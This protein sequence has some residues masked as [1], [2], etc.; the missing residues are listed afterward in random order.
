MTLSTTFKMGVRGIDWRVFESDLSL[1]RTFARYRLD[2]THL[3]PFV[4]P[5]DLSRNF[6]V[7]ARA[8]QLPP[9]VFV[10]PNFS[11]VPP[12]STADDDLSPVH[13]AKGQRFVARVFDALR[14]STQWAHTLMIVVYDEHGGFFDHVAPPGTPLG[15]PELVGKIARIHPDGADH[16]GV[17]VPAIFASPW[18]APGGVCHQVFDHTSI[19]KTILLRHRARF[20]TTDFTLLGP[21]VN[22]AAHLGVALSPL[23]THDDHT[24][25]LSAAVPA[26]P[27]P[28]L[29]TSVVADHG[30][31]DAPGATPFGE[32]LYRSF[33]PH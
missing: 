22:Q 24:Q 28:R 33:L 11:D 19:I 32:A 15:P 23:A 3:V 18:V 4:D 6:E 26:G 21:R 25:P 27:A 10:E 16:L 5:D 14:A 20:D 13:L 30:A 31:P 1:V 2:A 8:G 12:L 29:V 9:V 7:I 17:R